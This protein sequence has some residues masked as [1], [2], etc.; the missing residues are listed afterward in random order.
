MADEQDKVKTAARSRPL[1]FSLIESATVSFS[2][3]GV[4]DFLMIKRRK[5]GT[6]ILGGLL[7]LSAHSTSCFNLAGACR[8]EIL[9]SHYSPTKQLKAVVFQRDCGA[10]TGFSIQIS[11]MPA[12]IALPNEGG[13][14]FVADTDH[15]KSPSALQ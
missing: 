11:I 4:G 15:G 12:N 14:V 1:T 3:F 2:P 5:T 8:N 7:L 9:G 13:N 10:T 6:T